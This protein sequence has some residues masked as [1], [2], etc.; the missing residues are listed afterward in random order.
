MALHLEHRSDDGIIIET[1]K[2]V[3]G[4]VVLLG[5]DH[6]ITIEEARTLARLSSGLPLEQRNLVLRIR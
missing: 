1:G 2:F 3:D 4:S 6:S 5:V